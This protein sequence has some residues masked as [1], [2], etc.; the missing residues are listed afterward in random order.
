[1]YQM[2]VVALAG[3][4]RSVTANVCA[5]GCCPLVSG[6]PPTYRITGHYLVVPPAGRCYGKR[7][8]S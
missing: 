8:N 6:S 3:C 1:M 7:N 2:S 5:K 4:S